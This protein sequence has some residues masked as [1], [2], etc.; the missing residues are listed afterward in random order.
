MCSTLF[1]GVPLCRSCCHSSV[2]FAC[3]CHT[4]SNALRHADSARC[5]LFCVC[6]LHEPGQEY[7]FVR[8]WVLS[9]VDHYTSPAHTTNATRETNLRF[10]RTHTQTHISSFGLHF[11][12]ALAIIFCRSFASHKKK[13]TKN[14]QKKTNKWLQKWT[15]L[16]VCVCVCSA[17][18]PAGTTSIFIRKHTH[19]LFW[20]LHFSHHI[21]NN[22]Y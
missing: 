21:H 10:V 19:T 5:K 2:A 22:A 3:N 18:T 11:I 1:A 15:V 16:I 17:N 20:Q 6:F 12:F 7:V 9:N 14:E 8:A 13:Q 4:A